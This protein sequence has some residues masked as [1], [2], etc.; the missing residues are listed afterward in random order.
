[1]TNQKG[2]FELQSDNNTM[3]VSILKNYV[4]FEQ[5][6]EVEGK[7]TAYFKN[8]VEAAAL[9]KYLFDNGILLNHL[10]QKKMSLEEQF[11]ALTNK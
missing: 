6:A 11:L 8:Q 9:N 1:M 5:A 7:V 2:Y 10:V 3:L 4:D